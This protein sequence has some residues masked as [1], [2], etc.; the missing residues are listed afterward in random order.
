MT[1]EIEVLDVLGEEYDEHQENTNGQDNQNPVDSTVNETN[2]ERS[3]NDNLDH[4][5][6][7]SDKTGKMEPFYGTD[8]I[9]SSS[10]D[11][12][13]RKMSDSSYQRINKDF[14]RIDR[15]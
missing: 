15:S 10:T 3:V 14:N 9:V 2:G 11:D 6:N 13:Q 12:F 7:S 8:S 1:F 5:D 4:E